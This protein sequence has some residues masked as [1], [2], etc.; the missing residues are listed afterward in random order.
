VRPANQQDRERG[1]SDVR[2][3]VKEQRE[4]RQDLSRYAVNVGHDQE[5]GLIELREGWREGA[6]A[7]QEESPPSVLLLEE[8]GNLDSD[9]RLAASA[10]AA[11]RNSLAGIFEERTGDLIA[12]AAL[13]FPDEANGAPRRL[14]DGRG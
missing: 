8:V 3:V 2:R 4:A 9:A 5:R 1:R 13:C 10:W 11:N 14:K 7:M 6:I 12:Q